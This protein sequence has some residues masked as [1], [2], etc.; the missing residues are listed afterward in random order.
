MGLERVALPPGSPKQTH[1]LNRVVG[2]TAN[3]WIETTPTWSSAADRSCRFAATTLVGSRLSRS[4]VI[5]EHPDGS[6][7]GIWAC[8]PGIWTRL[9]MDAEIGSFVKG[10]ALFHSGMGETIVIE[11]GDTVYFGENSKG[12]WEVLE[13]VRKTYLTFKRD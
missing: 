7:A 12:T 11:A 10:H 3:S 9:V 2:T 4:C 1:V 6:E 5:N 8:T 13:T